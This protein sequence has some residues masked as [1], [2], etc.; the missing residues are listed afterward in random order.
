MTFVIAHLLPPPLWNL[1]PFKGSCY[2][3]Y[4]GFI[5]SFSSKA[6]KKVTNEQS[7]H[8]FH[9]DPW[10]RTPDFPSVVA[11]AY[12]DYIAPSRRTQERGC[13]ANYLCLAS[14]GLGKQFQCCSFL[15]CFASLGQCC[16]N[17]IHALFWLRSPRAGWKAHQNF[18]CSILESQNVC[19]FYSK[20]DFSCRTT[21]LN[22]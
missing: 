5:E 1:S 15:F 18:W 3:R 14:G 10:C 17:K 8:T 11:P 22:C 2:N 13:S 9:H 20:G 16:L 19:N 21:K 4:F 6:S 12:E 7:T